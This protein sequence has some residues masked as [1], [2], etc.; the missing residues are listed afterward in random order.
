MPLSFLTN[1]ISTKARDLHDGAVKL[2]AKWDPDAVGD[3]QLLEWDNTAKEMAQTAARASTDAKTARDT[4]A[5]I[6]SNVERYTAAAEKLAA[7]GNESAANRAADQALEWQQRLESARNEAADSEQ[8]ANETRIA[9][10]NAQR[11]VMQGRQKIETAK[12]EQARALQSER[13]SEQRRADRERMAGIKTGLDGADVAINAM[14]A[15]TRAAR[16]RA[17]ANDIRSGVL[18]QAVETDVAIN[19]ALAEVDGAPGTRNLQGK[20]AALRSKN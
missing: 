6:E 10:E 15:N 20:L 14:A 3:A 2:V 13:V 19:A 8:W 7:A 18:G 1:L 16:E 17:Q 4:L 11:L 5:N 9:A 12:R